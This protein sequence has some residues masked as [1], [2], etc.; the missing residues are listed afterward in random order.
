MRSWLLLLH[1]STDARSV[2]RSPM[3]LGTF[4]GHGSGAIPP[5]E[6]AQAADQIQRGGDPLARD[7]FETLALEP[8]STAVSRTEWARLCEKLT[9]NNQA[10]REAA[11]KRLA[12]LGSGKIKRSLCGAT[13]AACLILSTFGLTLDQIAL[14]FG[15]AKGHVARKIKTAGRNYAKATQKPEIGTADDWN[16]SIEPELSRR[17][18]DR[19]KRKADRWGRVVRQESPAARQLFLAHFARSVRGLPRRTRTRR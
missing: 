8:V 12:E 3:S 2:R 6:V 16:P 10:T 13:D 1:C 19:L 17:E 5:I 15:M 14:L 7:I 9:S 4:S 11:R 18:R